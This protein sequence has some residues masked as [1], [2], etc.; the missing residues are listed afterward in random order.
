MNEA[1][2]ENPGIVTST[3][4]AAAAWMVGFADVMSFRDGPL[5]GVVLEHPPRMS[6][7]ATTQR[8]SRD[9]TGAP[10]RDCHKR[11]QRTPGERRA[12]RPPRRQAERGHR[13]CSPPLLCSRGGFAAWRLSLLFE[14]RTGGLERDLPTVL[15]ELAGRREGQR[16]NRER[17]LGRIDRAA[18]RVR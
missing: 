5:A 11:R 18:G 15:P 9:V 14:D 4:A 8:E 12:A 7:A 16:R 10:S 2:A 1:V 3:M 6:A 13:K 17:A